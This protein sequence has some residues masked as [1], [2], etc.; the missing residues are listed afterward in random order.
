ML[1]KLL[2]DNLTTI[3]AIIFAL[4]TI[5]GS[6]YAVDGR[7]LKVSTYKQ[8]ETQK[9]VRT[10]EDQLFAL[11]FKIANGTATDFEKAMRNRIKARL[12]ALRIK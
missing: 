6:A 5:I 12:D 2:K 1:L 9:E 8:Y 4:S 3:A 11:D 7:Y 10:L